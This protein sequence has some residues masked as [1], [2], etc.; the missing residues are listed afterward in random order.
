MEI[1]FDKLAERV[2]VRL[3][4]EEKGIAFDGFC[5]KEDIVEILQIA[6]EEGKKVQASLDLKAYH[7]ICAL[8][9]RRK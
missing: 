5:N 6:F 9:E 4:E 8:A 7:K 3:D 1:D 2:I